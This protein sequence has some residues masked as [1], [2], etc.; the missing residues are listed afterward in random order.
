MSKSK[1]T[2]YAVVSKSTLKTLK[3]ASTR[4]EAR[5]WKRTSGKSGLGIYDRVAGSMIR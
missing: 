3:N 1:E 4:E 5:T 2:R